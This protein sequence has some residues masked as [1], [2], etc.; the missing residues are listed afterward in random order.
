MPYGRAAIKV[1]LKRAV[2]SGQNQGI[3]AKAGENSKDT[4][5][6]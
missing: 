2:Q 3:R 5:K 1:F 4:T 6:Y